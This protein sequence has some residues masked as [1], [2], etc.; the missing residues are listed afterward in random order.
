MAVISGLAQVFG[1]VTILFN[2]PGA[3]MTAG[4][5]KVAARTGPGYYAWSVDFRANEH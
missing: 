3:G 1:A 4:W 2:S 5:F